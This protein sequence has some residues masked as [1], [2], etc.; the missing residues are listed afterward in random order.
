[1]HYILLSLLTVSIFGLLCFLIFSI[2]L[3]C[4]KSYYVWRK[5][6][7]AELKDIAQQNLARSLVQK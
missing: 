5:A 7:S 4:S 1:M 3:G 6:T 2:F